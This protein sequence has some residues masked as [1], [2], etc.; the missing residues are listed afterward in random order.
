MTQKRK[1]AEPAI[2]DQTILELVRNVKTQDDLQTVLR[3]ITKR[4]LETVLEA[5]LTHQLGY[6]KH[7]AEGRNSGN[8]RNGA[9]KKTVTG[10]V[11]SIDIEIPRD[12]NSEFEPKIVKKHERRLERMEGQILSMYARGMTTRDI[13]SHLEEIY[14]VDVSPDLISTV[15]DAV[16]DELHEWQSRPL[17][18]LYLIVW[19]DAIFIKIRHEGQIQSR[20]IYVAI[21][22]N[23][24]GLK[25]VLGLWVEETEGAKFWLKTLS[26]IKERG[27]E[28]IL[29][30]SIDG[31][32]GF[33]QAIEAVFPKTRIQLCLVHMVRNSLKYVSFKDRRE[34]AADL[35][36]VYRAMDISAAE[37]AINAF[38]EKWNDKYPMI[39]K[40]WRANWTYV[41]P[42]FDYPAPIRK[43]MYTTNAI[44][45]LNFSLKKVVKN[46][47]SFPSDEA[48]L[49]LL[50]A[51][52]KNIKKRWTMPLRDW[53]SAVNQFSILFGERLEGR[54]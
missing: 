29:I 22:L 32:K 42:L 8:S 37:R 23:T 7:S 1:Q 41:T 14:G 13:R 16:A 30:A 34:L 26:E 2:S 12:R 4:G 48:A 44:E 52:L 6:G 45:S 10:E 9:S 40:S 15:T 47:S 11:G 20:A 38:E 27:V 19:L 35:K 18:R 25:E 28:D 53:G 31:L 49:K 21:G 50:F 46:R 36:A 51:A 17:D 33:P 39:G 3:A 43:V 5:E 54:L 24:A